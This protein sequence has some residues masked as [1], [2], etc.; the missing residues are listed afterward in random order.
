MSDE[1]L[2]AA[3]APSENLIARRGAALSTLWWPE[4][5][6]DS[7]DGLGGVESLEYREPT[8]ERTA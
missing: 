4:L 3:A 7:V 6:G 1:E 2:E 8:Q 5:G